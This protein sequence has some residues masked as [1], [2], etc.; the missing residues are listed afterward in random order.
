MAADSKHLFCNF[1]W[2]L[3]SQQ[4]IKAFFTKIPA[5]THSTEPWADLQISP[6]KQQNEL[7]VSIHN[8]NHIINSPDEIK[9]QD[10][11]AES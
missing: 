8:T 7:D 4:W 10:F 5:Y 9:P 6:L 1:A 11:N 3:Y 2:D